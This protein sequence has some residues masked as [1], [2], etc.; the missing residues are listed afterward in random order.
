[1]PCR[2]PSRIS[3]ILATTL[4]TELQLCQR[5]AKGKW[6]WGHLPH[7]KVTVTVKTAFQI[8]CVDEDVH[9]VAKLQLFSYIA[10]SLV[11]LPLLLTTLIW[12]A[13]EKA[14]STPKMNWK[15]ISCMKLVFSVHFSCLKCHEI[16]IH[17][18]RWTK[19]A[20]KKF[21]LQKLKK[22]KN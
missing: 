5:R 11:S 3:R 21:K 17:P 15:F 6:F 4:I 9:V 8:A 20:I 19:G 10:T 22:K 12:H 13:K 2:V 16:Q 7:A 14:F 1:M 18:S